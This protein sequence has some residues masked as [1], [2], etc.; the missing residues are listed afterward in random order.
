M[1]DVSKP[2]RDQEPEEMADDSLSS[3]RSIL[4]RVTGERMPSRALTTRAAAGGAA[5]AAKIAPKRRS[6]IA[7]K[8]AAARW[9]K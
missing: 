8:A 5:R 2:P 7:A 3:A 9:K 1:R 6:E 4:Q